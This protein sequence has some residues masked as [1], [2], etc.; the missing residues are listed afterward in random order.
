LP[1]WI[2]YMGKVLQG[3]PD[4]PYPVPDGVVQ[5]K[6]NPLT[7]LLVDEN[8]GGLYEYFYQEFMPAQENPGE[9]YILNGEAPT[10][11]IEVI[12]GYQEQLF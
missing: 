10:G 6:I 7:G 1:V 2:S 3:V 8:E 9:S 11:R 12:P 4:E 5:A